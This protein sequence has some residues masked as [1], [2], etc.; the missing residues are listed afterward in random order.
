MFRDS[1][2]GRKIHTLRRSCMTLLLWKFNLFIV[3]WTL[4]WSRLS[5]ESSVIPLAPRTPKPNSFPHHIPYRR[6]IIMF[7][8]VG[9]IAVKKKKSQKQA[10]NKGSKISEE[11]TWRR[12]AAKCS[13]WHR[14]R[15]S[16]SLGLPSLI[17]EN[18]LKFIL[19]FSHYNC[20][21]TWIHSHE[22]NIK[23]MSVS[24]IQG[25]AQRSRKPVFEE[26]PGSQ[27]R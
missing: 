11:E 13:C 16:Q 2:L 23:P 8:Y 5:S 22:L 12:A 21:K 20:V 18:S 15:M 4:Q 7:H 26:F 24:H 1:S 14:D 17:N 6:H 3:L 25:L 9:F 19:Y 10:M 27:G